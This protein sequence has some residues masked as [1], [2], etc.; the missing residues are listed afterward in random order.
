MVAVAASTPTISTYSAAS[1]RLKARVAPSATAGPSLERLA[2]ARPKEHR[3]AQ[4]LPEQ[5]A[6]VGLRKDRELG[7]ERHRHRYTHDREPRNG[8]H[9]HPRERCDQL[10]RRTGRRAHGC[11][12]QNRNA[13]EPECCDQ[14]VGRERGAKQQVVTMH[15]GVAH[16][17]KRSRHEETPRTGR[18]ARR[19]APPDKP[20]RSQR[21]AEHPHSERGCRRRGQRDPLESRVDDARVRTR[22]PR[23]LETELRAQQGKRGSHRPRPETPNLRLDSGEVPREQRDGDGDPGGLKQRHEAQGAQQNRQCVWRHRPTRDSYLS[24]RSQRS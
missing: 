21:Q 19:R 20:E 4:D 2:A 8:P 13:S 7:N 9:R 11:E 1:V 22:Q 10:R 17:R 5:Q 12:I 3:E 15:R 23:R 18:Q 14:Y 24:A 6:S 16:E